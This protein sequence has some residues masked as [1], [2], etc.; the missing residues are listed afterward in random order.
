MC[1]VSACTLSRVQGLEPLTFARKPGH[2]QSLWCG[3]VHTAQQDQALVCS[4]LRSPL[5][6]R[7]GLG[8]HGVH[9]ARQ[10]RRLLLLQLLR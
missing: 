2:P 9:V 7:G 10:R 1:C 4:G 5:H 6:S 3:C 8:H